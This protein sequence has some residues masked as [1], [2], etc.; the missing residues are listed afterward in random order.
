M[1]ISNLCTELQIILI[2]LYPN[3]TRILPADVA[4]F[5]PLKHLWK[6]SVLE[7]RQENPTQMLSLDRVAPLLDTAIEKLSPN[8]NIIKNGFKACGLYPWNLWRS[9]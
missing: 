9:Q 5:K 1:Q 3:S 6:K 4:P 2:Y 8:N 7:W